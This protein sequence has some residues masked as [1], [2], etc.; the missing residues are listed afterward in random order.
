MSILLSSKSSTS[1]CINGRV[2][3]EVEDVEVE[4]VDTEVDE[5]E[6]LVDEVDVEIS[7]ILPSILLAL[8]YIDLL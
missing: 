6:E 7:I 4:E 2:L 5:V 8:V 1:V 3:V